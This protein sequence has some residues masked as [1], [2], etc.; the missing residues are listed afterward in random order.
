M[1][2]IEQLKAAITEELWKNIQ[3]AEDALFPAAAVLIGNNTLIRSKDRISYLGVGDN[4]ASY[5]AMNY[6]RASQF[7]PKAA[8]PLLEKL[9]AAYPSIEWE[10]VNF[11]EAA[12]Y[13]FET[14]NCI[15]EG[16]QPRKGMGKQI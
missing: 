2:N 14:V 1:N 5:R 13:E 11:K 7:S 4:G 12:E 9:R 16:L 6:A 8:A 10:A 15:I 3:R